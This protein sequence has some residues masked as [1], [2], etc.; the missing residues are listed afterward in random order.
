MVN[1]DLVF[2]VQGA[3]VVV[4]G[5]QIR[6]DPNCVTLE[7]LQNSMPVAQRGLAMWII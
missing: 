2:F 3:E 6:A 5:L 4:F 1:S 7:N